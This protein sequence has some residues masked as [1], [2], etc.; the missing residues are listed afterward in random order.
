MLANA[1]GLAAAMLQINPDRSTMFSALIATG[2]VA[3]LAARPDPIPG[4]PDVLNFFSR[5]LLFPLAT[6]SF[7]GLGARIERG[8]FWKTS[9]ANGIGWLLFVVF[10]FIYYVSYD[11]RLGVPN[12]FM[13]PLAVIL[14]GLAAIAAM[15]NIPPIPPAS[16]WTLATIAFALLIVPLVMIANWREP[17]ATT[18]K[19]FPIRVMTYNLHNGFNTAG[20]LDPEALAQTI[21]QAK[22]DIVGLQEV[23]RG[24]AIDSSLDMIV[25]LSQRLKMPFIYGPTA[26]PV[27]GNAILS[28]YPIREWGNV[29]LPPRDLLLK[30]GFLWA[31]IDI[32]GG[33]ELLSIATH[34]H[35]IEKDTAIRQ[36]QSPEIVKFWNQRARTIFLGDLNAKPDAK[37]IAMLRDA[38][39]KDAFAEIGRGDGFTFDSVEPYERIDYIWFSPDLKVSDLLIPRSTASDHL[40]IAV[41]VGQ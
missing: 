5:L 8:G 9:V 14:V 16:N 40:G 26:D 25:W 22:P 21:E 3:A 10:M 18:G 4:E 11:I 28:R 19:G 15:R 20:R 24:W 33:E 13:P 27:W 7:I 1:I 6:L 34:Y 32:G 30:R 31:R 38:G 37:E 39:L 41:T 23:E 12:T 29:P 17:L 36:Q 35:H 2:F